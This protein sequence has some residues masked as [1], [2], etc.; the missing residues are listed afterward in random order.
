MAR[1]I[2]TLRC[3]DRA[4]IVLAAAKGI[5]DAGG[6]I[7]ES[8]QFSDPPTGLFCMRIGFDSP[9]DLETVR[10]EVERGLA[11]FSPD[12]SIRPESS[13]RRVLVMVSRVDHCLVDLLYRWNIGE[14]SVDVPVIVSNHTDC[15]TVAERYGIPFSHLLVDRATRDDAEARLLGLVERHG[16]DFI[17][18]A[19]YMQLLSPALCE[20][21]AG[22]I[23][24]IHHSFLPGFSGA[25]PYRQAYER[26]VKLIGATA[27]YV[28]PDLDEGPIIAQDVVE[29][30]HA[31]SVERLVALG[32][33]VERTVLARAV[34]LQAEDRVFLAG[35]RT[36]VF[37]T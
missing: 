17:V 34:R 37:S 5:V 1:F 29:V 14:L 12:L 6:N 30:T 28:T 35:R 4:G 13:H 31:Q 24:N 36:I 19:R 15:A 27:H 18:L 26:G 11:Q 10:R 7:V 8:D 22:R 9:H 21:L 20:T 23:I 2:L 33:D 32:R 25:K 3:H 16:I